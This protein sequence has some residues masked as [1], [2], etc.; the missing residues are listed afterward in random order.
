MVATATETAVEYGSQTDLISSE[1]KSKSNIML[2]MAQKKKR[3]SLHLMTVDEG[4]T[5]I[6]SCMDAARK[7]TLGSLGSCRIKGVT[8]HGCIDLGPA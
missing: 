7:R 2:S 8:G 5:V 6:R 4:V 3:G 1:I